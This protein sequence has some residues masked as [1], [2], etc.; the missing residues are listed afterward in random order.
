MLPAHDNATIEEVY[1]ARTPGSARLAEAARGLFPSGVTHDG[2]WLEPYGIYVERAAGPHKWDVDGNRYVDWFGGHGALL[3]GHGH[4]LVTEAAARALAAMTHPGANHPLELRWAEAIQR[5]VP[6]CEKIRFTSSGTEATLMAVR[7]ARAFTGRRKLVRFRTHFHGW[8]DHMTS[9]WQN[10]MDGTATRGVLEGVAEQV[11]LVDPND[12][13]AVAE[14]LAT[15][16]D[17]AAVILEP[18]G[19]SF[20]MVPTR[21]GFP[22]ALRALTERHGVLLIFDEVVTGFRVA[23]G[24]AQEVY[25][26]RPDLST[27]AK[28][29]AGGLP[30][31][32]V[33]GRAEIL[34]LLDFRA[35]EDKGEE[36]IGHP[37][38]FNANPVSAAAGIATL[39]L[40]AT[41]EPCAKAN[42]VAAELRRRLNELFA[43]E[44]VP[45]AAY[46]SFSGVHLFV[47]PNGRE[48][49]PLAFDP[50]ALPYQELKARPPRLVHRLRLALL[51][52][53][54]DVSGQLAMLASATH[55]EEE[56]ARTVEAFAWAVRR[57]ARE[58]DLVRTRR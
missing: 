39:E 29:V 16:D 54:V 36:K 46:G 50:L 26:L 34:D 12:L 35:C 4:P 37:G 2:R 52:G 22:Q 28:V 32:A 48:I 10:H 20:G 40:V 15:D 27:F 11:V 5:L 55:G 51:S 23:P 3:L 13:A 1:R 44:G 38:T 6:S 25:A 47:N 7:L 14:L 17:I 49:D 31:G 53:G 30:G 33:G 8:H 24:G 57:L 45:W 9:G 56:V 43:R 41:G 19:A 21:E 18:T 58:G 42:G